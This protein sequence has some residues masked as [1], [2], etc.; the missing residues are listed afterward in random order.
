V[1]CGA[2]N[3]K[4]N[5]PETGCFTPILEEIIATMPVRQAGAAIILIAIAN[6]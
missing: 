5:H 4:S 2:F 6:R 1:W 3:G